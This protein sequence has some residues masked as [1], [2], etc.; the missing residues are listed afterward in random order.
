MQE[1]KFKVLMSL[2]QYVDT[3]LLEKGV[4]PTN[5]PNLFEFNETL[6]SIKERAL[7]LQDKMGNG[8]LPESYFTNLEQ[9]QLVDFFLVEKPYI[10]VIENSLNSYW[11]EANKQLSEVKDLGDIE[12]SQLRLATTKS[13]ATLQHL[14]CL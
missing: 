9:C 13:K 10:D 2:G 1:I 8:F 3:N 5:K 7:F 11:N 6:L 14:G 12:K 4:Y